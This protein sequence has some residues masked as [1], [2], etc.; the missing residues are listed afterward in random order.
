MN[1]EILY[2]CMMG[3]GWFFLVGWAVALLG[4]CAVAFR[5]DRPREDGTPRPVV[6]LSKAKLTGR[7]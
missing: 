5:R 6:M 1:S 7:G 3:L 4:A 2:W